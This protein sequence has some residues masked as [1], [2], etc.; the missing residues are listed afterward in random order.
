MQGFLCILHGGTSYRRK[1]RGVKGM[2]RF[3]VHFIFT[4]VFLNNFENVLGT[5]T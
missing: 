1:R 3:S 5:V 2:E 4:I